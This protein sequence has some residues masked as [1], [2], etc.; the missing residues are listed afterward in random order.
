MRDYEQLADSLDRR[1]LDFNLKILAFLASILLRPLAACTQVMFRMNM[2]ERYF[3][4][5]TFIYSAILW[6]VPSALNGLCIHI[7]NGFLRDVGCHRL[8]IWLSGHMD[9]RVS[10]IATF[11]TSAAFWL[12]YKIMQFHL[13]C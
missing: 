5:T 4:E 9:S 8:A 10:L 6:C 12:F 3:S 13:P 7:R 1:M 2:G 11:I